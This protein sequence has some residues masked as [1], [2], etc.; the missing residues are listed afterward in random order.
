MFGKAEMTFKVETVSNVALRVAKIQREYE[1]GIK[2][3]RQMR[4][5][6]NRI[7]REINRKLG[8][9]VCATTG[10]LTSN[11][12][13]SPRYY[14]KVMDNYRNAIKSLGFK[15]H[16]IKKQLDTFVNKYKTSKPELV[17]M[18]NPKLSI[19][20]LRVNFIK[21][22]AELVN[23]SKIKTDLMSLKFEHHAFYL[24]TPKQAMKIQ[25]KKLAA[26][27]LNE[28]LNSAVL[29]NPEYIEKVAL[30]LL[31]KDKPSV[32][33][34]AV[35]IALATGRR[36]TEIMKT[37]RFAIINDHTLLFTG[38]LKT[39]NRAIFEEVKPY[40][41]PCL[42][43]ANIIIAALKKLRKATANVELSYT[44]AIGEPIGATLKEGDPKDY[45]H[46]QAVQIY[47]SKT[48][49]NGIRSIL[50]DGRFCFK[51]SR[52]LY[53]AI[54]FSKFGNP[55]ESQSA[56]RK[57]T[58]GHADIET[59]THYDSF[60]LSLDVKTYKFHEEKKK[61]NKKNN[62]Q[63]LMKLKEADDLVS[64][65][66]RAPNMLFLHEWLKAQVECGL[67]KEN[68]TSGHLRRYCLVNGKQLSPAMVNRYL[69]DFVNL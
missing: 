41:I 19:D 27:A 44:N 58:L 43:E 60:V 67:E 6:L 40:K 9:S 34:L 64:K 15:H 46:N 55:G 23:G 66:K 50:G 52:A 24:F 5:A 51:D 49:N 26:D 62:R 7:S 25:I 36:V 28:K 45:H 2:D 31:D 63:L 68:I 20:E 18:L 37:A 38:Q 65:Y 4:N 11:A 61:I 47:Y 54:C 13:I 22:R 32:T 42:I 17:K 53:T 33:E 1:A 21:L 57:R 69:S 56:F 14:V 35:G 29:I 12:D 39:K 59:Q 16:N 48:L 3:E 30:D 10:V 8:V